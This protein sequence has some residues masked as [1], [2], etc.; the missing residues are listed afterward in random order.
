MIARQHPP[1][2]PPR[3][4]DPTAKSGQIPPFVKPLRPVA[5]PS[6]LGPSCWE[7]GAS[8]LSAPPPNGPSEYPI[9]NRTGRDSSSLEHEPRRQSRDGSLP[10]PAFA[11]LRGRGDSGGSVSPACGT[12]KSHNLMVNSMLL[13][14]TSSHAMTTYIHSVIEYS[15]D[16][17]F[18]SGSISCWTCRSSAESSRGFS[19]G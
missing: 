17:P 8:G 14:K 10:L 12:V 7:I 2:W 3:P 6:L 19:T 18:R 4:Q 11:S 13:A 9:T 5:E 16:S 15:G 1:F